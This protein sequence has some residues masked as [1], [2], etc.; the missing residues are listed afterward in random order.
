M[1]FFLALLPFFF[2]HQAGFADNLEIASKKVFSASDYA[3]LE[4]ISNLTISP[5]GRFI[6]FEKT[7]P[8][9]ASKPLKNIWMVDLESQTMEPKQVTFGNS[10]D[11]S[12]VWSQDSRHLYYLSD[13][14]KRTHPLQ[15]WK[16]NVFGLETQNI[17]NVDFPIASFKLSPSENYLVLSTSLHRACKTAACSNA[18]DRRSKE[19]TVVNKTISSKNALT[20]PPWLSPKSPRL[21]SIP[22]DSRNKI[23]DYHHYL[24]L[25]RTLEPHLSDQHISFSPDGHEL[26]FAAKKLNSATTNGENYD[27]YSMP[28]DGS[29][30]PFNHSMKSQS[31]DLFPAISSNGQWLA[32]LSRSTN[33]SESR[34]VNLFLKNLNTSET[35]NISELWD[36]S[37]SDF[38]FTPDGRYLIIS[39]LFGIEQLL[40]KVNLKTKAM[41]KLINR[42]FV[43]EFVVSREHIIYGLETFNEPK[44]YYA[45]PL[46]GGASKQIT[47]INNR[48][49]KQFALSDH[50]RFQFS[51]YKN[52]PAYGYVVKPR[53]LNPAKSQANLAE[54]K[55]YP[56][57][58]LLHG[59]PASSWSSRFSGLISAQIIASLGY[60]VV[61]LGAPDALDF[62]NSGEEEADLN[63][64]S[65]G[66]QHAK[67][68]FSWI[69]GNNV[70]ALSSSYG[71]YLVNR[72]AEHWQKPFKC[73]VNYAGELAPPVANH[74]DD[75]WNLPIRRQNREFIFTLD[76]LLDGISETTKRWKSPMLILHNMSYQ[77]AAHAY[78]NDIMNQSIEEPLADRMIAFPYQGHAIKTPRDIIKWYK[79]VDTWLQKYLN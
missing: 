29:S 71:G 25:R 26:F 76:S 37:I 73:F 61:V 47:H 70:C 31:L 63:H 6:A 5:S 65:L 52:K 74:I 27:I 38:S 10:Q 60:G 1:R 77:H 15:V 79:E 23:I 44:N 69:D 55:K 19:V 2:L 45:I 42:G 62:N 40:Y 20:N 14:A 24:N 58:L 18:K 51:G 46:G 64:L 17:T 39:A 11:F 34:R 4:L 54:D 56:T 8:Q 75:P 78:L 53:T 32:Y 36:Q 59:D 3:S 67:N 49:I 66:F 16:I 28:T 41:S 48:R 72:V 12:P 30:P 43:S 50:Q 33:K 68:S 57:V 21:F 7:I 9:E 13:R 22:T 35:E